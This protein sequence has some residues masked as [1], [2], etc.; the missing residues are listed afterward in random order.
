[1]FLD[2][3]KAGWSLGLYACKFTL[4][5]P[6]LFIL[7]LLSAAAMF[8]AFVAVFYA[9]VDKSSWQ[10]T[11]IS[12]L[13][14][15]F[16][17]IYI[18]IFFNVALVSMVN[19]KLEGREI[20]IIQGFNAALNRAPIILF[21]SLVTG[22]VGLVIR[23]IEGIEEKLHLPS[24]LSFLLDV[25]WAAATYFVVP[26]ICFQSK[27][28]PKALYH[29]SGRLIKNIWGEGV[30]KFVG[31]SL[32]VMVVTLPIGLLVFVVGYH[33]S[34]IPNIPMSIYGVLGFIIALLIAFGTIING[35]LQTLFYKYADAKFLPS[36]LSENLISK[37]VIRKEK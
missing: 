36:G 29:E 16:V 13:M 8:G 28:S 33:L 6:K 4:N 27:T 2:N 15:Y 25:G 11:V 7:P 5:N 35:T 19:Q 26:I 12:F 32:F 37:A 34:K 17:C 9:V 1:M 18:A 23:L 31:A 24:I 10:L 30:V 3:I 20:S 21:W 22:S 14:A